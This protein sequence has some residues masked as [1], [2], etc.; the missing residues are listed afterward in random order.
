MKLLINVQE[1]RAS[2]T[3]KTENAAATA[4]V[5]EQEIRLNQMFEQFGMRLANLNSESL[6]N[7]NNQH[8]HKDNNGKNEVLNA[9]EKNEVND[10][11]TPK[12]KNEE[13]LLNIRV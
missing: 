10:D 4:I 7:N 13:N 9:E 3:I 8:N 12:D 1:D 2:V 5:A 11:E 6:N